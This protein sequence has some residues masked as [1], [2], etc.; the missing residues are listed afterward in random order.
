M[1]TVALYTII[2]VCKVGASLND[3]K[4]YLGFGDYRPGYTLSQCIQESADVANK[5]LADKH[6]KNRF[7]AGVRCRPAEERGA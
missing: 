7:V 5:W 2:T 3:C 1:S 6:V 4:D